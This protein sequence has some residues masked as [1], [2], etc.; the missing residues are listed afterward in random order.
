MEVHKHPHHVMHSKKWSEYLLEFFMLFFA[1]FLGFIAENLRENSAD[2]H[3]EKEY[4][5]SLYEDVTQDVINLKATIASQ[6]QQVMGKDSLVQ[7]INAGIHSQQDQTNFYNLHWKYVG[8]FFSVGFSKR[9]LTQLLN[10]GGLRLVENKNVSDA[11]AKYASNEIKLET[12]DM[13]DNAQQTQRTMAESKKFIDTKYMR[14]LPAE[15]IIAAPYSNP[16]LRNNDADAL[17]DFSFMLEIDKEN[18]IIRIG[19]LKQQL[20]DAEDLLLLL[21]KEYHLKNE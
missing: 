14:A 5:Q 12:I 16:L 13:P 3:R 1:V 2:H 4:I 18:T 6:R 8:Y 11:I 19:L 7:L 17:K 10:S 21:K 15:T 20:K 9:T